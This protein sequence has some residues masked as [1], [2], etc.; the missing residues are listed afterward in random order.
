MGGPPPPPQSL[1]LQADAYHWITKVAREESTE[2][3]G[4]GGGGERERE[5][6][7]SNTLLY[8]TLEC[9]YSGE[10]GGGEQSTV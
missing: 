2:G 7:N 8:Q 5:R 1:V 3:E 9:M 4:G 6:E 10:G